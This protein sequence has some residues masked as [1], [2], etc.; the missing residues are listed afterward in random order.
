MNH[1]K[2]LTQGEQGTFA[3]IEVFS[4]CIL[5]AQVETN[6]PQGGDGGHGG[7]TI[8]RFANLGG[9]DMELSVPN[10]DTVQ[11]RFG[12]DAELYCVATALRFLADSLESYR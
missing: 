1:T 2:K 12:G 11:I 9:V 10:R 4:A 6:G 8:L 5:G 3:E 7:Y